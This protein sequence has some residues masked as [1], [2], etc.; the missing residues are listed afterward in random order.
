MEEASKAAQYNYLSPA[1]QFFFDLVIFN[2]EFYGLQLVG[3][4]IIFI[5]NIIVLIKD[6]FFQSNGEKFL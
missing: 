4:G 1:F 3:I 2:T 6:N 5:A